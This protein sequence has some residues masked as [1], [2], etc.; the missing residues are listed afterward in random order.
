MVSCK[1]AGKS[2]VDFTNDVGIPERLITDGAMEFT[3]HNTKFVKEARCM[4]IQLHTTEQVSKNQNFAA[5][6]EI[7]AVHEQE[8]GA[9]MIVGLQSCIRE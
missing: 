3:G 9:K 6:S 1:D 5:E 7:E 4:H 8:T 2:L